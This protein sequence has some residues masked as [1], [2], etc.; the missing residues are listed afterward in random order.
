MDYSLDQENFCES[1]VANIS[2]SN[3]ITSSEYVELINDNGELN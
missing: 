1:L 2:K 3:N